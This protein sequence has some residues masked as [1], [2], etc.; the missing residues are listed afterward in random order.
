VQGFRARTARHAR[1]DRQAQRDRISGARRVA[2]WS[3]P[4][5][6]RA[7]CALDW[8]TGQIV[9]QTSLTPG[10]LFGGEIGSA[11]LVDGKLI[12]VSNHGAAHVAR[13]FA[14]DPASGEVVWEAEPP[15]GNVF[16]PIGAVRGVA[17]VG[18]DQGT[19]TALDTR[20]GEALWSHTA[21]ARA[22]C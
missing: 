1:G 22:A 11:A 21:P 5:T 19:L 8:N 6:R 15:P 14:L 3:A 16:A 7:Y 4:G 9:S 18:T 13:V 10:G 17:F 12:T 2:R 20:T